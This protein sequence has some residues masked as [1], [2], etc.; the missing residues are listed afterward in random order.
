MSLKVTV[1]AA[2]AWPLAV[3][4]MYETARWA[5]G[6]SYYYMDGECLLK[7]VNI[8]APAHFSKHP[9]WPYRGYKSDCDVEEYFGVQQRNQL[10]MKVIFLM[11]L[12]PALLSVV[13]LM[14]SPPKRSLIYVPISLL[15]WSIVFVTSHY[16][17]DILHLNG[18]IMHHTNFKN[19]G[20]NGTLQKT[21]PHGVLYSTN[22]AHVMMLVIVYTLMKSELTLSFWD[23]VRLQLPTQAL[24]VI[25]NMQVVHTYVHKYNRSIYPWPLDKFFRDYEGHVVCHHGTGHCLG[26]FPGTS[27]LH[28]FLLDAQGQLY[29]HGWVE[30]GSMGEAVLNLSMDYVLLVIAAMYLYAGVRATALL[31]SK[32]RAKVP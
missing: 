5:H 17:H 7:M 14:Y 10:E 4:A 23:F 6:N 21:A 19:D 20:E 32:P 28:N 18:N 8:S 29:R 12:V 2:V 16:Q 31:T 9:L 25:Y 30:R 27:V 13:S 26:E 3:R 22:L 24:K 11:I 1:A 15:T